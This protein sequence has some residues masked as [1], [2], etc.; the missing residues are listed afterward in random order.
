[1][2]LR[3]LFGLPW[4]DHIHLAPK[5]CD[6]VGANSNI[7]ITHLDLHREKYYKVY[8]LYR[9]EKAEEYVPNETFLPRLYEELPKA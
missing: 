2:L 8:I 4:P 5:M 9:P 1:M 3:T 6:I 7:D